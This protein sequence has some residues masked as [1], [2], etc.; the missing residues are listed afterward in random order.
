MLELFELFRV[1][2]DAEIAAAETIGG[3]WEEYLW[4]FV[5]LRVLLG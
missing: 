2:L 1:T 3:R 4:V 5:S